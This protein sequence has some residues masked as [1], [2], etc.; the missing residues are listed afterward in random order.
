M[1]DPTTCAARQKVFADTIR[2]DSLS[3]V[4]A[5]VFVPDSFIAVL[6]N[7]GMCLKTAFT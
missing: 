6:A 4:I 5:D 1:D 2:T 3:L 7:N